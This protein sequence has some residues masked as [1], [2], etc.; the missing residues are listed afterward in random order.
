MPSRS[1]G[2]LFG[3]RLLLVREHKVRN[4]RRLGN[5]D[6]G[7]L[8]TVRRINFR[9]VRQFAMPF[10]GRILSRHRVPDPFPL[11]LRA[12]LLREHILDVHAALALQQIN[13][14]HVVLVGAG[15]FASQ[16][17]AL[18]FGQYLAAAEQMLVAADAADAA[19]DALAVAERPTLV[20]VEVDGD[21]AA[22]AHPVA[23][24]VGA[25]RDVRTRHG[26]FVIQMLFLDRRRVVAVPAAR[27]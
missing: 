5:G 4:V 17:H 23:V 11:A 24:A 8:R 1:V 7:A 9:Y 13:H 27:P 10:G 22:V 25:R 3:D 16:R 12:S 19:V 14:I 2:L 6:D 20:A 15:R 18:R 26:Q 21:A